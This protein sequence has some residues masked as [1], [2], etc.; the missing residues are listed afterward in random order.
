MTRIKKGEG[1]PT[2]ISLPDDE[3][4]VP[5]VVAS[6]GRD[7]G[8]AGEWNIAGKSLGQ[9]T[10]GRVRSEEILMNKST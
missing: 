9:V 6:R 8:P 10:V 5:S 3:R 1:K 7:K 2:V 4:S